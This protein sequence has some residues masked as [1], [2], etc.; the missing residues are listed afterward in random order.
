MLI[1]GVLIDRENGSGMIPVGKGSPGVVFVTCQC[2]LVRVS[3]VRGS[4]WWAVPEPKDKAWSVVIF[5]EGNEVAR[6]VQ[7]VYRILAVMRAKALCDELFPKMPRGGSGDMPYP[8][9][10]KY[11]QYGS[12]D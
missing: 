2:K 8:S 12:T 10:Y 7:D 6:P 5:Q 1:K 4:K 3:P 11:L 9:G